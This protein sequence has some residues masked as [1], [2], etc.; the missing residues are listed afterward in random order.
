MVGAAV[1]TSP[2][3]ELVGRRE[4]LEDGVPVLGQEVG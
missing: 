2:S 1:G 3:G 4:G